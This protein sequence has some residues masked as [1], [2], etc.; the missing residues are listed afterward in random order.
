M[1]LWGWHAV[2]RAASRA[3]APVSEAPVLTSPLQLL[4]TT[5]EMWG[6]HMAGNGDLGPQRKTCWVSGQPQN[7]LRIG[8]GQGF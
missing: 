7:T 8:P 6:K 4:V 3:P 5:A 2:P 1:V